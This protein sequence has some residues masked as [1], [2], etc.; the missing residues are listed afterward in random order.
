[1][2]AVYLKSLLVFGF[3][4]VATPGPTPE[5]DEACFKAFMLLPK[6]LF[7]RASD[8]KLP[9]R[10]LMYERVVKILHAR[11]GELDTLAMVLSGIPPTRPPVP[12]LPPEPQE[13]RERK[14]RRVEA[15]ASQGNISKAMQMLS[16][17]ATV[18]S[19]SA[20]TI[21]ALQTLH[22]EPVVAEPLVAPPL[23]CRP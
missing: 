15:V 9:G 8:G 21:S 13:A 20:A 22:V 19:T 10:A 16:S 18:A 3:Q 11:I 5:G 4:Q 14:L 7:G 6:L 1:M 23:P 17:S 2:Q 12:P